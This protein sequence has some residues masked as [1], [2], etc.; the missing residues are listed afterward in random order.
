MNVR[1]IRA[2]G[3]ALA[4]LLVLTGCVTLPPVVDPGPDPDTTT[5]APA[6]T[7][8]D[9]T[10]TTW[11]VIS[12]DFE[13]ADENS[14]GS[15]LIMT[16]RAD[17]WADYGSRCP[18]ETEYRYYEGENANATWTQEG[19]ALEVDFNQGF[20]VCEFE[21]DGSGYAGICNNKKGEVIPREMTLVG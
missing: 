21:Y 5:D 20:N 15:E 6:Q 3:L 4:S 2:A 9:I 13:P 16:F 1:P 12:L 7:A 17:G 19:A 11:E 18:G 8:P 10:G 14:C